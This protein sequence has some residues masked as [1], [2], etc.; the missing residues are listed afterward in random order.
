MSWC[1]RLPAVCPT[2]H[3][4]P[5]A[6][7]R[8]CFPHCRLPSRVHVP[9]PAGACD[10][11][12]TLSAPQVRP[13]HQATV[14]ECIFIEREMD[15][16]EGVGQLVQRHPIHYIKG[17][18]AGDPDRGEIQRAQAGVRQIYAEVKQSP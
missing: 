4:L 11:T 12:V 10:R 17:K 13:A 16:T 5:R 15:R 3:R 2:W 1:L 7:A 9:R 18:V 6:G 14:P 8:A